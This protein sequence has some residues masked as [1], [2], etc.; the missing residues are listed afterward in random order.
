MI[1]QDLSLQAE[2]QDLFDCQD[3]Q[4]SHLELTSTYQGMVF[5]QEIKP[6]VL[7]EQKAVFLALDPCTCAAL[8]GC[9]HLHSPCLS[10]PI[11]GRVKDLSPRSGMFSL[12]DLS[13]AHGEWV[14]RHHERVQTKSPTYVTM[15]YKEDKFRAALLDV[16]LSGMG[17]LVGI[18]GDPQIDFHTNCSVSIDFQT[19]PNFTWEKLGGAIHYQQKTSRLIVR[20]GIRLY[21]KLEQARQLE[22]Y[23]K[24]RLLEISEELE[25]VSINSRISSGVEYQYF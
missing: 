15:R 25:Q 23:I 5:R 10:Q 12:T 2:M 16:S 22:R 21:P 3:E 7:D 13:Y 14:E 24:D 9:V 6:V 11:R 4:V 8:K 17:L 20:L 18:S 19:S 1:L